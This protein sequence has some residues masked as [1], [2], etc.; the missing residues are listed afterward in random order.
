MEDLDLDPLSPEDAHIFS[1]IRW[2]NGGDGLED[3]Y[4]E[5]QVPNGLYDVNLYFNECCCTGR[6]FKIDVQGE[7]I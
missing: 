7:I 4:L 3:F 6:H 2:D 1:T 5:L